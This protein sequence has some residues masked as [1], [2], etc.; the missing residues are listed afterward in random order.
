MNVNKL[1][2][3]VSTK[4]KSNDEMTNVFLFYLKKKYNEICWTEKNKL[5]KKNILNFNFDQLYRRELFI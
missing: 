5:W 4:K 1:L 2:F 3:I